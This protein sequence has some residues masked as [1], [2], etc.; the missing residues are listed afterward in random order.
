MQVHSSR[1]FNVASMACSGPYWI[2]EP[3]LEDTFYIYPGWMF[4][5]DAIPTISS[6]I[7]DNRCV[8]IIFMN[9]IKGLKG[10]DPLYHDS[11]I[12]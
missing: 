6:M 7:M 9:V 5:C 3:A 4:H 12:M 11:V 1:V 2:V 8:R 10:C